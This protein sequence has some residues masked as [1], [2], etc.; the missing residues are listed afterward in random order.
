MLVF[1]SQ[2]RGMAA[3]CTEPGVSSAYCPGGFKGRKVLLTLRARE[4]SLQND[5]DESKRKKNFWLPL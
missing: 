4:G 1:G 3:S 5:K 2:S